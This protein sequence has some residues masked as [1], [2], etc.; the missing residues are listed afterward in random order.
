MNHFEFGW[1]TRDGLEIH[2]QGWEGDGEKKAVVCLVHGLGEHSGR[3]RHVAEY[4]TRA[5]YVLLAFDHRG[6]GKSQG[7]RGHTA[8]YASLLDDILSDVRGP[9]LLHCASGN[10]VGALLS[11]RA[12][13]QGASPEEAL[14]LGTEAGL[15][16]LSDTVKALINE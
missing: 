14:E 8:S 7:K 11:L 16:S 15:S 4:L 12:H 3:Y 10:R 2:A 9:V 5:G 6:H 1:K 13:M